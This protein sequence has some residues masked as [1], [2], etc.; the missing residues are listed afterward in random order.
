M[1]Q[2][3]SFILSMHAAAA[4]HIM[5]IATK[6]ALAQEMRARRNVAAATA[7]VV[8]NFIDNYGHDCNS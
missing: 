2:R 6:D 5:A 8:I 4:A 3:R 7:A 1:L